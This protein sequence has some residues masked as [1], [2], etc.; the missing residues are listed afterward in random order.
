MSYK[1]APIAGVYCPF[2]P[3]K[4]V[5]SDNGK[6][7]LSLIFFIRIFMK[8]VSEKKSKRCSEK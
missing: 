3:I 7:A 1:A 2:P 6:D 5:S 8:P 4:M